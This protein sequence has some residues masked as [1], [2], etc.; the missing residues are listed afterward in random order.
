MRFARIGA[1]LYV[2]W[3]LLHLAAAY[4]QFQLA[5]LLEPGI[6]QGKLRQGA[7]DILC[8]AL[9][10]IL[11]AALLNWN[12]RKEGYWLNLGVVSAADLGFLIF[13]FLPGYAPVVPG[14]FGPVLWV[15]AAI[16]STI[17]IR[18]KA[19]IGA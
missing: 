2:L 18:S 19:A 15:S 10:S 4:E 17:G 9:A 1:F 11:I 3:G 8:F 12:N 5:G 13:V 6:V 16:F 14:I 7:W